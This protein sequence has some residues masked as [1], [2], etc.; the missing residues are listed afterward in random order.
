MPSDT[1]AES[2]FSP[3]IS[4][5][6]ELLHKHQVR[7]LI[8]GG[9]AVIFYGHARYTGDVDIYALGATLYDLLTGKPPFYTGDIGFQAWHKPATPIS[10][11]LEEFGVSNEVPDYVAETVMKCLAKETKE[12]PQ[13][14]EE[15]STAL[16]LEGITVTT[17]VRHLTGK[18]TS[19]APAA[20]NPSSANSKTARWLTPLLF[21]CAFIALCA[22]LFL[23]DHTKPQPTASDP[24]SK[25]AAPESIPPGQ[26]VN[27]LAPE[28]LNQASTIHVQRDNSVSTASGAGR[29]RRL[30]SL[31]LRPWPDRGHEWRLTNGVLELD[32]EAIPEPLSHE[33]TLWFP[34]THATNFEVGYSFVWPASELPEKQATTFFGRSSTNHATDLAGMWSALDGIAT[35]DPEWRPMWLQGMLPGIFG[36][37]IPKIT[38]GS[39]QTD[40]EP[41]IENYLKDRGD[42]R[43][44]EVVERLRNSKLVHQ[45]GHW[46]LIQAF[47]SKYRVIY[48]ERTV[49]HGDLSATR[50]D[51]PGSETSCAVARQ[52]AQR[53]GSIGITTHYLDLE[54]PGRYRYGEILYRSFDGTAT[55]GWAADTADKETQSEPTP[56]LSQAA[57][58]L[59]FQAPL[60]PA[61]FKASEFTVVR[62]NVELRKRRTNNI[63]QA[64]IQPW[65]PARSAWQIR[66][67]ILQTMLH[68]ADKGT[69]KETGVLLNSM[70]ATD[71]EFGFAYRINRRD[72]EHGTTLIW[73]RS[74]VDPSS[75]AIVSK[76]P[77]GIGFHATSKRPPI[78]NGSRDSETPET[79]HV[80]SRR[81]E[82]SPDRFSGDEYAGF[83]VL[84][85][86]LKQT[87][88]A[89]EGGNWMAIRLVGGRYEMVLS[90]E[91]AWEGNMQALKDNQSESR[92]AIADRLAQSSGNIVV[93]TAAYDYNAP[94]KIEVEGLYYRSLD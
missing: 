23:P 43:T 71:L 20:D 84:M 41:F 11:R 37:G 62:D 77:T 89:R 54:N 3:D 70:T 83:R 17:P 50:F 28:H 27:L 52:F 2:Y 19:A 74:T 5:F 85:E 22:V 66:D 61:N 15:I 34:T 75:S 8:V 49:Y 35:S 78:L 53:A 32:I 55:P 38:W 30:K 94:V 63:R 36:P 88:L 65:F 16:R 86:Q 45:G 79:F 48:N 91:V 47:G 56:P 67:G 73:A 57:L 9:E 90:G 69:D 42:S 21:A 1:I 93:T 6:L 72:N 18:G 80:P 7:Y 46:I 44:S 31:A 59:G 12:R 82:F 25:S 76:A 4:E 87:R 33:Y 92:I 58:E 51:N 81:S 13:S 39:R 60:N 40:S 29:M 64:E 24:I 68:R 14:V 26:L 10:E